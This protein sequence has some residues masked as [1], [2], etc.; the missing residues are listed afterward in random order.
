MNVRFHVMF[1]V[2]GWTWIDKKF[3]PSIQKFNFLNECYAFM[4]YFSLLL[5]V[6]RHVCRGVLEVSLY[7]NFQ[8]QHAESTRTINWKHKEEVYLNTELSYPRIKG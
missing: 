6:I 4:L 3:I 8:D 5:K 1:S 7:A 2:Y